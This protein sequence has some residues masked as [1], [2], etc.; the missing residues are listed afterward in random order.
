MLI[1]M[2]WRNVWRNRKRSL[3]MASAITIGLSAGIFLMAFYNGMIEQRVQSA[4]NNETSHV[5]FHH[6]QFRDEYGVGYYIPHGTDILEAIE[7]E[8]EVKSATGRLV[9]QGMIASPAGS[10]GVFITGILPGPEKKVT[11]LDQRVIEGIYLDSPGQNRLLLSESLRKKLKLRKGGKAI[12][13][14][15]DSRGDIVSGAFRICGLYQTFNKP[16]DDSHVFVSL[17]DLDHMTGIPGQLNEIAVVLTSNKLLTVVQQ[18]WRARYPALDIKNWREI[19]PEIGLTVSVASQMVY[20]FMGI[21]LLALAFGI[22]NTMMMSILERTREI[23]MLLALG[24][25]RSRVFGMVLLETIALVLAGCP[26]GIAIS[27]LAIWVTGRHGI[28][29]SQYRDVY[30]SFG[31]ESIIYPSLAQN[32]LV[33]IMLMVITTSLVAGLFPAWRVLRMGPVESLKK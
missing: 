8:T 16:F 1:L 14:F 15:Q 9:L 6:P 23:G 33:M 4:I 18:R 26:G 7:N 27:L 11:G 30:S 17:A 13:S 22:I 31:Y 3:I 24:M 25:K 20:I 5:Q 32:Q 10:S 21:I 28:S 29:F 2:A 19:A 12:L